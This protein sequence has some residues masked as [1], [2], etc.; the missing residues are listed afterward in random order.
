MMIEGLQSDHCVRTTARPL[1]LLSLSA[2]LY[3]TI[4]KT[5]TDQVDI[6]TTTKSQ[7]GSHRQQPCNT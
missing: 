6:I 5:Y 2:F 3:N 4:Q 7:L 1:T